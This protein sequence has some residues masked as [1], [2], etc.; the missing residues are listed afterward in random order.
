[1][2]T[3]FLDGLVGFSLNQQELSTAENEL[4]RL[5]KVCEIFE[6]QLAVSKLETTIAKALRDNPSGMLRNRTACCV[7]HLIL[8][9]HT[10]ADEEDS[11]TQD[12][13]SQLVLAKMSLDAA[14]IGARLFM[15]GSAPWREILPFLHH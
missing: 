9:I 6:L 15:L 2:Q 1:M 7:V 14:I 4:S 12:L 11:H 3:E 8:R 10:A 13:L 5:E